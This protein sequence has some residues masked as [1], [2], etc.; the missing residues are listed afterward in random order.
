MCD[1]SMPK[2]IS[3]ATTGLNSRNAQG[4]RRGAALRLFLLLITSAVTITGSGAP[5]W[6]AEKHIGSGLNA[7]SAGLKA[8]PLSADDCIQLGGTIE[9]DSKCPA[10]LTMGGPH[11]VHCNRDGHILCINENR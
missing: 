3:I 11:R 10:T 1:I 4:A 8:A 5:S 7:P 9:E 2:T 6:S